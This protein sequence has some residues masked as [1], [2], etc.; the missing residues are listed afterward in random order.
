MYREQCLEM[1]KEEMDLLMK[2]QLNAL[3]TISSK[4]C[5]SGQDHLKTVI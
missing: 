3:R 4:R 1:Y 2:G 5:Q